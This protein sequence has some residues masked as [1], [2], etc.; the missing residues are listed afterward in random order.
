MFSTGNMVSRTPLL[1]FR[2]RGCN[3]FGAEDVSDGFDRVQLVLV[4]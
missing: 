1:E 4:C 3:I 2:V